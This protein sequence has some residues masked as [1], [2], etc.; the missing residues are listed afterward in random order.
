META[1]MYTYSFMPESKNYKDMCAVHLDLVKK[2]NV[3]SRLQRNG[4]I[5]K[6]GSDQEAFDIYYKLVEN[7]G[8]KIKLFKKPIEES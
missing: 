7:L 5:V 6:L 1:T 4:C 3:E 8:I 2:Q